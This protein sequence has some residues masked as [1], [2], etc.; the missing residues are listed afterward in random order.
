MEN[1][2]RKLCILTILYYYFDEHL[3]LVVIWGDF[4]QYGL[5]SIFVLSHSRSNQKATDIWYVPTSLKT[6]TNPGVFF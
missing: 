6:H 4:Q 1:I 5:H 3:R 2:L